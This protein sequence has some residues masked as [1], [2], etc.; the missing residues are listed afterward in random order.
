MTDADELSVRRAHFLL[1][2][3]RPLQHGVEVRP[4]RISGAGDGLFATESHAE[5]SIV[6]EYTGIIWPN[7]VAWQ[8]RD[9]NY[10]MKLGDNKYVDALYSRE[11][12]ARYINDCRGRLGGYN[13]WFDK[14]PAEDRALVVALRDIRAGE[15]LFVDYGRFYWVGYNLLHP[16][17]PVR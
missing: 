8:R 16:E 2:H 14:R 12:L 15:E 17:S 9:K 5:G 11:V 6:C 3:A 7:A 13:V 4:S 10:L 1:R